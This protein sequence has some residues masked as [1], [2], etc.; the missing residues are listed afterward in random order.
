MS[1]QEILEFEA[2]EE[3]VDMRIDK[4]LSAYHEDLSRSRIQGLITSDQVLLNGKPLKA[5]SYKLKLY[6]RVGLTIPEPEAY[7][8]EA[9]DIPLSIVFEDEYL[10]VLNKQAGLVVHPGAGNKDGT[11]VNA[12]LHHCGETLSGIGGVLRPGIVHRLD[13]DTSGL[14]VVA[15]DDKTHQGLSKQLADRSLSRTYWAL[16]LRAPSPIKGVVDAALGRQPNNRQKMAVLK[17]DGRPSRTKYHVIRDY[18]GAVSLVECQLETGRTHQIRVHMQ[19]IKHP[20][21]GDPLY[22]PQPTALTG[23]FKRIGAGQELVD[24]FLAFPRQALHAKSIRFIHP[25]TGDEHFYDFEVPDDFGKLLKY[26]EK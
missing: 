26:M 25:I 6:D 20:L 8:P 21:V 22:G 7:E 11:L 23:A 15:K 18:D 24:A 3:H 13:K 1:D 2:Q 5:A 17:R 4:A 14:M 10:I 9:Q 12:L 19:Y 16:V